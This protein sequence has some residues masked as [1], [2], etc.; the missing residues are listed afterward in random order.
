[1]KYRRRAAQ[2]HLDLETNVGHVPAICSIKRHPLYLLVPGEHE[3]WVRPTLLSE[4][5]QRTA[6]VTALI[7]QTKARSERFAII[8][9][10]DSYMTLP[11]PVILSF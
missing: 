6:E 4:Q 10:L 3:S 2:S 1:M 11:P 9:S 5:V 8:S 7:D